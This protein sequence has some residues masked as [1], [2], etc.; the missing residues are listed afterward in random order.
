MSARWSILSGHEQPDEHTERT[1]HGRLLA[2]FSRGLG[3]RNATD[4]ELARAWC[5]RSNGA[6]LRVE[7]S[8]LIEPDPDFPGIS[9]SAAQ[10]VVIDVAEHP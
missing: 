6:L 4:P 7:P 2:R 3:D 8:G 1:R 9:F 5:A 10:A